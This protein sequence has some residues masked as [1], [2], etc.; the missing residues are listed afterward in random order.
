M[1]AH[2]HLVRGKKS[3]DTVAA[4]LQRIDKSHLV[5]YIHRPEMGVKTVSLSGSEKEIF[6]MSS[7][8]LCRVDYVV[9]GHARGSVWRQGFVVL[10]TSENL[11]TPYQIPLRNGQAIFGATCFSLRLTSVS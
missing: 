11:V 5:G 6:A 4:I 10:E 3:L 7:G 9:P 2:G 8:C 1:V